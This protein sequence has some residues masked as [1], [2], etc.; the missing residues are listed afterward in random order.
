MALAPNFGDKF[1]WMD[2]IVISNMKKFRPWTQI[3]DVLTG[4]NPMP[5]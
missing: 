1:H 5:Q 4:K 2:E 3:L